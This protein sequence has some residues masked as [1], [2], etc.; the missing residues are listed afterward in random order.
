MNQAI[1]GSTLTN[2][3]GFLFRKIF[4]T[5]IK[6]NKNKIIFFILSLFALVSLIFISKIVGIEKISNFSEEILH[7]IDFQICPFR[8]LTKIGVMMIF[9]DSK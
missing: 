6:W 8:L 3:D 2:D 5:K 7:Q 1:F 4:L 9:N